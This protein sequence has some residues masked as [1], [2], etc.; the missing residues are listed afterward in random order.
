M[1][2]IHEPGVEVLDVSNPEPAPVPFDLAAA[3]NAARREVDAIRQRLTTITEQIDADP[4]FDGHA[5]V[6]TLGD[7]IA[8]A[9]TDIASAARGLGTQEA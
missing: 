3:T 6:T 4:A 2:E 9:L 7:Q 1:P 8:A 5:A